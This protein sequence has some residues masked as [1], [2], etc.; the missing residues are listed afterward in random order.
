[1]WEK[2]VLKKLRNN[3]AR[4]K[5]RK[6]KGIQCYKYEK[7]MAHKT[8]MSREKKKGNAENKKGSLKSA[9]VM[10]GD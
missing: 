1:V 3:K 7:N 4:S 10:E 6:R 2:Q 5:S 8:R 9:N